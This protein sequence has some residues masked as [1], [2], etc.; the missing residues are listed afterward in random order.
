L[1]LYRQAQRAA[2]RLLAPVGLKVVRDRPERDM[3]AL[4]LHKSAERGV[5]TVL[6]V[7][8]NTGQFAA[9]LRRR[10]YRG[11]II[12][13]EPLSHAHALMLAAAATDPGWIVAERMALGAEEGEVEINV[14]E[15]SASSSLLEVAARS[16]EAES[17]TRFIGSETTPVRRL[18]DVVLAE[19]EAPLAIKLDTQGF[20]LEVLRGAAET[21]KRT[22]LVATEISLARLYHGGATA[23]EVFAFLDRAGFRPISVTEGFA[24]SRRHEVL[25]V[26]AVFVRDE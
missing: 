6:D 11:P 1:S 18:D 9:E 22:E 20:E 12:S 21:L 4:L 15:N 23:S 26:D 13:F 25:Q 8:A 2:N 19:W 10:G 24:D 5:R 7:G 17:L 16:I 14:S 3:T